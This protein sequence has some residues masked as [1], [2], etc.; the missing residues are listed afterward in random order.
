MRP[1]TILALV[2]VMGCVV[3]GAASRIDIPQARAG[4]DV[5]R[6]DYLCMSNP[7]DA[8]LTE[9]GEEGWELAA[10]IGD[11]LNNELCFKRPQ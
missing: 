3:G 8:M 7:D 1:H 9:A 10:A 5:Q 11:R 4:S 6:W 2:F